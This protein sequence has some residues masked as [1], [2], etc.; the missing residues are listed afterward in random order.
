MARPLRTWMAWRGQML[1]Q[2]RARQPRHMLVTMICDS[3]H[4]EQASGKMVRKGSEAGG[5]A[6]M[7]S[8]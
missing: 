3:M 7:S 6:S 8:A 2:G 5:L 1:V 4:A